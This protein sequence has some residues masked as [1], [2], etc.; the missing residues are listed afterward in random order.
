VTL[1]D[2]GSVADW[3]SGIGT[4]GSLLLGFTI[5]LRERLTAVKAEPSKVICWSEKWSDEDDYKV[6]VLNGSTGIIFD[7]TVHVPVSPALSYGLQGRLL[8]GDSTTCSVPKS[9][10][11]MTRAMLETCG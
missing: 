11:D 2:W 9:V 7:V 10:D 5:L 8:P 4:A 1:T 3:V 6:T